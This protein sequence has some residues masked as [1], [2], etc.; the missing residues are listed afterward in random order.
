MATQTFVYSSPETL[1]VESCRNLSA[2]D[3]LNV[4]LDTVTVPALPASIRAIVQIVDGL[5]YTLQYEDTDLLG[6]APYLTDTIITGV[7]IVTELERASE[8]TDGQLAS[9]DSRLDDIE[10]AMINLGV[11]PQAG[12]SLFVVEETN[13]E[14]VSVPVFLTQNK[15]ALSVGGSCQF[16]VDSEI[17]GEALGLA[18]LIGYTFRI[19]I[20]V[21][22]VSK[23]N[24]DGKHSSYRYVFLS[25][26]D[27]GGIV[28]EVF[29]NVRE[30]VS[31]TAT[32]VGNDVHIEVVNSGPDNDVDAF[33][34]TKFQ[35]LDLN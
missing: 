4:E 2:G 6:V 15:E 7:E 1:I 35:T 3:L 17:L 5:D 25:K 28:D 12:D 21:S 13:Y 23:A 20:D 10:A 8:Y 26:W 32:K 30:D 16:I 14:H 11:L 34:T 24:T 31:V 33:V 22:I 9:R 29:S 19:D 18:D 27:K